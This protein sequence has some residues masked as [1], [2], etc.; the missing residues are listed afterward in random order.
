VKTFFSQGEGLRRDRAA[1]NIFLGYFGN[2]DILHRRPIL[3][4]ITAGRAGLA[5]GD[6]RRNCLGPRILTSF[7]GGIERQ[8]TIQFNKRIEV[9]K[10]LMVS[11]L[12][13]IELHVYAIASHLRV[14]VYTVE[15]IRCVG[16]DNKDRVLAKLHMRQHRP[17]ALT[18]RQQEFSVITA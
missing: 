4:F 3:Y 16:K 12:C 5:W 18:V 14:A 8:N 1:V 13:L 6:I 11:A 15:G 7:K 10:D 9:A 17:P 2:A